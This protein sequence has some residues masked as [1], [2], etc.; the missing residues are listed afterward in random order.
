MHRLTLKI[1][2]TKQSGLEWDHGIASHIQQNGKLLQ[3]KL[4][5]DSIAPQDHDTASLQQQQHTAVWSQNVY[6][7]PLSITDEKGEGQND[8]LEIHH[9]LVKESGFDSEQ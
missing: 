2:R 7:K 4:E 5:G 9:Q 6:S 8:S 3:T 1:L